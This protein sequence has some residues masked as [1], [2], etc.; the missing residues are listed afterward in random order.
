MHR[1]RPKLRLIVAGVTVVTATTAAAALIVLCFRSYRTCDTLVM[2][3]GG[4]QVGD[5]VVVLTGVVVSSRRG[6]V[7]IAFLQDRL[8]GAADRPLS[9]SVLRLD[10]EPGG[11]RPYPL[12]DLGEGIV[13]DVAGLILF[14]N[15][16]QRELSP[17]GVRPR[18]LLRSRVYAI[19]VPHL[20]LAALTL[21][22]LAPLM[23][24]QSRKRRGTRRQGL[25]LCVA[26]GYDLRGTPDRC[27]ECGTV[28]A[29]GATRQRDLG[30]QVPWRRLT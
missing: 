28:P 6:G 23:I 4:R 15:E 27:P 12:R 5:G 9:R 25:R 14:S 11:D 2:G 21:L 26:C 13:A 18:R 17:P 16:S 1:H 20:V 7:S 22:P 8:T 19:A 29:A 24:R 10:S 3:P 30:R